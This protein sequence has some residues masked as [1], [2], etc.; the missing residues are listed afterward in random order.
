[1]KK[2]KSARIPT[3]RVSRPGENIAVPHAKQW[4]KLPIWIAGAG[5]LD[6][7]GD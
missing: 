4:K 3:V 5:I 7:K 2:V 6:A 1:V